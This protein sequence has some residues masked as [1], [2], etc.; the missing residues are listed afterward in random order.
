MDFFLLL[1]NNFFL[2]IKLTIKFCDHVVNLLT[3]PYIFPERQR[4]KNCNQSFKS[5]FAFEIFRARNCFKLLVDYNLDA[6]QHRI[7]W[8]IFY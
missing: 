6:F 8:I 2:S 3:R 1:E 5:D 7:L 4:I